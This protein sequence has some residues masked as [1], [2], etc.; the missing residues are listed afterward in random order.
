LAALMAG[1]G[2][3]N[4]NGPILASCNKLEHVTRITHQSCEKYAKMVR[5]KI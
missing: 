4:G 5:Y 2:A 3:S 1:G